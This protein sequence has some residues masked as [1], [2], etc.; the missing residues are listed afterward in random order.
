V[1]AIGIVVDDAIA[2]WKRWNNHIE[3]AWPACGDPVAMEQVSGP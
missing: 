3:R 1:L 2:W